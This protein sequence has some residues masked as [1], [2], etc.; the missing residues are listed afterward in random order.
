MEKGSFCLTSY[1]SSRRF[2]AFQQYFRVAL[3]LLLDSTVRKNEC[4]RAQSEKTC[5]RT[6]V[7]NTPRQSGKVCIEYLSH[8]QTGCRNCNNRRSVVHGK[9]RGH[10]CFWQ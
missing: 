1:A 10:E 8:S 7:Y 4:L 3:H 2:S 6:I 5:D 9:R